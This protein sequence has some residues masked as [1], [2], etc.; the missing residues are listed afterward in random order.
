[1]EDL[2]A[3]KRSSNSPRVSTVRLSVAVDKLPEKIESML[4]DFPDRTLFHSPSKNSG[5]NFELRST[6]AEL[7]QVYFF[8]NCKLALNLL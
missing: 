3:L 5:T 4:T 2:A 6:V 1:M 8:S 7:Y